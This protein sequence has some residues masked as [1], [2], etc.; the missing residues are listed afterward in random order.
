MSL[1]LVSDASV[2][3]VS[4][5]HSKSPTS[6]SSEPYPIY[7]FQMD[8]G[9]NV[10][11]SVTEG[12]IIIPGQAKPIKCTTVTTRHTA[13]RLSRTKRLQDS[14][15]FNGQDVLMQARRVVLVLDEEQVVVSCSVKGYATLDDDVDDSTENDFALNIEF[16]DEAGTSYDSQY[17]FEVHDLDPLSCEPYNAKDV[18][19]LIEQNDCVRVELEKVKQHY[20]E[21]DY[22]KPKVLAPGM[23]AIDVKPIPHPLKNN[24][25]AHLNYISH[26]KE[27][28]ETVREIVEEARVIWLSH[29]D[30]QERNFA[31]GNLIDGSSN[32]DHRKENLP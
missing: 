25:S 2:A 7:N 30:P 18:T 12:G 11:W 3:A 17:S 27:S 28:V 16:Y 15:Y 19:A 10:G 9:S 21:F 22:V 8:S 5:N 23:Y 24:R 13:L 14:D 20:K 26:L 4:T 29:G 6:S 1:A 31:L 32:G